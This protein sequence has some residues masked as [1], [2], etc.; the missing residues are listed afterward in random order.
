MQSKHFALA[1][2]LSAFSLFSIGVPSFVGMEEL[3]VEVAGVVPQGGEA[4]L[5]IGY[6]VEQ[7]KF[8]AEWGFCPTNHALYG[9]DDPGGPSK[10]S[11]SI[12]TVM[13]CCPLP[14]NDILTEEHVFST[15]ECPTGYVATGQK[16]SGTADKGHVFEMRCT[17]IN[18]DRYQL[19]QSTPSKYWGDGAAGWQ[20]SGRIQWENIPAGIRF[21]H[22]RQSMEK[23]DVD[24]C[25]SFPWGS[26]LTKKESKYCAG[27]HFSQLQFKGLPGDPN[28]G[29]PVKMF[30]DCDRVENINNPAEA[31]CI[32]NE[33]I[34][35][36]RAY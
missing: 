6:N 25:A 10:P 5:C 23:W 20:G 31:T 11:A 26:L 12:P 17:K 28:Q 7:G 21:A 13:S 27:M 4:K 32:K 36:A 22:G 18:Q 24:G 14:A 9:V 2:V 34:T 16:A 29:T 1:T 33:T 8:G 35:T 30:P 3:P 15:E 19:G